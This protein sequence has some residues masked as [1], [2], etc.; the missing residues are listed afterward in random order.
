MSDASRIQPSPKA[1]SFPKTEKASGGAIPVSMPLGG[2]ETVSDLASL[3]P[4]AQE[5]AK[6]VGGLHIPPP[7]LQNLFEYSRF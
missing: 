2:A 3:P 4:E 1:V 5:T 6:D 7:A